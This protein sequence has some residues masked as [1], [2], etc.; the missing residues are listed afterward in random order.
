LIVSPVL[1]SFL[2]RVSRWLAAL[3]VLAMAGFATAAA[4]MFFW[5][6]PNIADHRDT[7]AALMSRALGQRVTLE[8]VSGVWQQT[9]PEFRLYGVRL[10]DRQGHP[11]LYL[12]ELEAA[13]AWRSL[14]FLEPRFTRIELQGLMLGVRHA[15]D[16][17]F[18]VGGIP[19]NPAAP[20]SGF[21]SWLLRQGQ[22]HAGGVAL[23]WFDEVRDA[24]PLTLTAV[25]FTLTNVRWSHRLQLRATPPA[26][27]SRP[28]QIVARLR[29]RQVDDLESWNGTVD[30]AA[31]EVSFSRLAAWLALPYQPQQ[32]QGALNMQFDVARGAL[33]GVAV[34]FDLHD[35]EARLG[36]ALPPVRLAQVRGQARW[37]HGPAGYR[38][39]FDNLRVAR[40]GAAL[41]AP[42]NAGLSWDGASHEITAQA[43]SLG[44]WQS[45]L[46]SLPMEA[47]LRTRLQALQP[48]GRFDLLRF[49]WTGTQPGLDNFS[50]MARFSGLGVAAIDNQPGLSNLSGHIEGDA[51][52][53]A[54]E[55][56]SRKMT[57]G[58]PGLFRD[59]SFAID[60]LRAQGT[61]QKTPRGRRLTLDDMAGYSDDVKLILKGDLTHFPFD[62]GKGMFQ[63]DAQVKHGVIDYVPGWPR[64][65]DIQGRL[66]F[67]GKTMEVTSNQARIYGVAL[68]PVKA[69]IPDLLHHDEQL[70]IDG[71]ANGP[72]RDFILFANTS[73]VG[74]RLRGFTA[75]LDGSGPMKLAL[76]LQMPLRHNHDTTLDG[77]L[78]FLNDTLLPSGL[79]RLDQTRGDIDFTGASLAANN[80]TAQFLGGPLRIDTQTRSGQVRILARGRVTAAGLTSWLGAA[81]KDQMSG[82]TAWR[83]EVDLEP[84]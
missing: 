55:I 73:P 20:D 42:F 16:G 47:A 53:G 30:A 33:A 1:S 18:Y 38:M 36:D 11:A 27:L 37:Q 25:D 26:S 21:S 82:Q 63:V 84:A 49:G 35:I 9:R 56:D 76:S 67:Q 43:F 4:L 46:P 68:A 83:G 57:L 60:S 69:V 15:R 64:I 50:I 22:V 52:A 59:P 23:T 41:G 71:E 61:W 79:P 5:I 58:L 78:S 75:A 29:A 12:P 28:L 74:E 39:A 31:A 34:G 14:L 62:S 24:P 3:L 32:G 2:R 72:I 17:H 6:L 19:I 40:P 7:V 65:E 8:A 54:F 10:Y 81:W 51:R 13:F 45:L 44:G 66:L 77:R 70:H 80:L 48:Q